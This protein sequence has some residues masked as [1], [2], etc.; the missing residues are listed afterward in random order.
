MDGYASELLAGRATLHRILRFQRRVERTDNT[1]DTSAATD[2]ASAAADLD[3]PFFND[4]TAEVHLGD[5]VEV[6]SLLKAA[7]LNG[8]HGVTTGLDGERWVVC[9]ESED[10]EVKVK[11]QNLRPVK[12]EHS[13]KIWECTNGDAQS[14]RI[15]GCAWQAK[16]FETDFG[17]IV[18]VAFRGSRNMANWV[19][20]ISASLVPALVGGQQGKVHQGF[21]DAYL[22][23]R[24]ELH[25]NVL[26][27]LT[28]C[29]ADRGRPPLILVSGHSLGAAL[30]TLAAYDFA[31]IL[32][33]EVRTIT[34][35]SPRVGDAEFV[36]SYQTAVLKTARFVMKADI[37]P[38]LPSNPSD[39]NDD[40]SVLG[41]LVRSMLKRPHDAI[42]VGDYVHVCRGTSLKSGGPNQ[43]N[44]TLQSLATAAGEGLKQGATLFFDHTFNKYD[45]ELQQLLAGSGLRNQSDEPVD[46]AALTAQ[47]VSGIVQGL[48]NRWRNR[49]HDI[50][51]TS[52]GASL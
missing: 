44:H 33:Q 3:T 15:S 9:L 6:H 25:A 30:A 34:W 40:G 46:N 8:K 14:L 24:D 28:E 13:C 11:E 49:H 10:R 4:S 47:A 7:N 42:G 26:N 20:N 29:Q 32:G 37:V 5:V 39:A 31:C 2:R 51:R 48:S 50:N 12:N 52:F 22:L 41:P 19:T 38:R 45:D 36:A 35:G 1:T 23:V 27:C 43:L 17:M 18:Q 16:P 21:Q